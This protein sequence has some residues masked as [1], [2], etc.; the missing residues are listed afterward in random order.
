MYRSNSIIKNWLF[1]GQQNKGH[2]TERTVQKV[3]EQ[4]DGEDFVAQQ[5]NKAESSTKK[6]T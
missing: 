4:C 3:F 6:L 5:T 2:I 1:P